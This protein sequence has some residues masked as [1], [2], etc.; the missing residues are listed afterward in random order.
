MMLMSF[1]IWNA[2]RANP[3]LAWCI[4][5]NRGGTMLSLADFKTRSLWL[6]YGFTWD[7]TLAGNG[8]G[9]S[10]IW[11]ESRFALDDVRFRIELLLGGEYGPEGVHGNLIFLTG[12]I[13]VWKMP[14]GKSL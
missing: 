7:G 1:H 3:I 2:P 5:H 6:P 9:T 11:N 8:S 13:A 12:T 10:S 4:Q 14:I